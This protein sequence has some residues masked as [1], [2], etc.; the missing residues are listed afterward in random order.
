[1][2]AHLSAPDFAALVWSQVWRVGVPLQQKHEKLSNNYCAKIHQC[3]L[4]VL[5]VGHAWQTA[6]QA[7]GCLQQQKRGQLV[8]MLGT[9]SCCKKARTCKVQMRKQQRH[10]IKTWTSALQEL[11][12]LQEVLD[13]RS[14]V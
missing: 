2:A 11:H 12:G 5:H 6:Q 9:C 13:N 3:C 14:S 10:C 7:L 8:P 4:L 1:M